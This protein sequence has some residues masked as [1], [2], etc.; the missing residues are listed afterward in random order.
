M[1]THITYTLNNREPNLLAKFACHDYRHERIIP[2]NRS[3]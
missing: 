1:M 2:D 3:E